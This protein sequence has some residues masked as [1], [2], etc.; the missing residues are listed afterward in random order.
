MLH[1]RQGLIQTVPRLVGG[2][3]LFARLQQ[4]AASTYGPLV[5]AG[6]AAWHG[7]GGNYWG[8]NAIIRT[9][10]FASCAGL[11][12]LPGRAPLGGQ[13]LSHDFVEAALLRRGGWEVYLVPSVGGSF[14]GCPPTLSDLIVRDRRWAQGNLQ[15][16]RLLT[17]PGL[18]LLS[19]IHLA[20]GALSY[21]ASPVW[22]LS[23][24][25]GVVLA[26]QAKYATPAYFGSEASLFP[27]WPVFDAQMA[28][29]LFFATVLVVHL[30]K[31]LGAVWAM[32]SSVE[33]KRHGGVLNVIGGVTLESLLSTLIAPVLMVTQTAAVVGIL[34]GRDA[35][36][37]AQRRVTARASAIEFL[38]QHR[39]HMA[40]GV[41][42]AVIC[43]SISSGVLAWMS[44]DPR[45]FRFSPP[46]FRNCFR[47]LRWSRRSV[48]PGHSGRPRSL[49]LTVLTQPRGSGGAAA[50]GERLNEPAP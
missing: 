47:P 41:L 38:A 49:S 27:K 44:P 6:L 15:H 45:R 29:S 33:R 21:L 26:V 48:A 50:V 7:P 16:M 39:W 19:R 32:R 28:L 14:E 13:I 46:L 11:P 40:W 9:K 1:R 34:T 42:G 10:A 8:H 25:V 18:P 3:T 20:M 24:L 35:G 12:P 31:L 22:A 36:W 2:Q 5:A 37:S 43:W 4:F 23:L 30:P 17:V